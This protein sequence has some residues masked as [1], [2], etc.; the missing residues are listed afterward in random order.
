M[1]KGIAYVLVLILL[2]TIIHA[3]HTATI[4]FLQQPNE[5]YEGQTQQFAFQV[6]NDFQSAHS[7]N[8]IELNIN[9]LIFQDITNGT[10]TVTNDTST[11]T[12]NNNEIAPFW[13]GG[14]I[15]QAKA[16][17]VNQD[18]Q[19]SLQITL[20]DTKDKT[21]QHSIDVTILND[22]IEPT[23]N[24]YTPQSQVI[25][26]QVLDFTIDAE[27]PQSGIKRTLLRYCST[28]NAEDCQVYTETEDLSLDLSQFNDY[29]NFQ[30]VVI[31]NA[32]NEKTTDW[33]NLYIDTEDPTIN[34]TEPE[35][36]LI[37]NESTSF[38]FTADDDS[39]DL[40]AELTCKL[41]INNEEFEQQVTNT[42]EQSFT[43]DLEDNV[44]TWQIQ[45]T[46]EAE[47]SETTL[48]RTYTKDSTAPEITITS[49]D[50]I[51]RTQTLTIDLTINDTT[52]TET[53]AQLT[54]PE[55]V[56]LTVEGNQINYDVPADLTTGTY[57][58]E[59]TSIDEL[60]FTSIE[61]QDIEITAQAVQSSG[62]SGGGLSS[63]HRVTG[64][65]KSQS[66]GAPAATAAA[67]SETKAP[68]KTSKASETKTAST[69]TSTSNKQTLGGITGK[70]IWEK[71]K[72]PVAVTV[73]FLVLVILALGFIYARRHGFFIHK[74]KHDAHKHM[75]KQ[76]HY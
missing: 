44:Y 43:P 62:G 21:T 24:S 11:S 16:P 6:S 41:I 8:K 3:Q 53:S 38:K 40:N 15:F 65:G 30:L 76:S 34:L 73:S 47:N 51:Q 66:S 13:S 39:F 37:T 26:Q 60:N 9:T 59:V 27:D 29:L 56:D 7:I 19:T 61:T 63:A 28:Q 46:D 58:L 57:S 50:T 12:W 2:A 31:D 20:T 54:G 67:T 42:N 32:D 52:D 49:P 10:W 68:T 48:A 17:F 4:N 70:T 69:E 35:D 14:F 22:D 36:N 71:S 23:I 55:T 72:T 45:C 25:K 18:T 33:E 74:S 75:S 5:F 64:K 1:K